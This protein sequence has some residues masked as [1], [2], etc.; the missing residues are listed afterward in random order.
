MAS[1]VPSHVG[2]CIHS[3]RTWLQ[4]NWSHLTLPRSSGTYRIHSRPIH[5]T[6]FLLM[7]WANAFIHRHTTSHHHHQHQSKG[8]TSS[9]SQQSTPCYL[10]V[11]TV[12]KFQGRDKDC[13]IVSLVRTNCGNHI[14][15]LLRDW[16]RVNVAFT[17][18]KKKLILVGS[19]LALRNI[20]IWDDVRGF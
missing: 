19:E 6:V 13:I 12:D 17:R 2:K 18:A 20:P 16:R 15:G 11:S 5:F 8:D 7:Y 4:C 10:E 3:G 9:I 1:S 14:G